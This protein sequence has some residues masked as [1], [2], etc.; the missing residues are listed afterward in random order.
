MNKI[1]INE[2][3][4]NIHPIYNLYAAN[5]DGFIINIVK[6]EPM[7][8]NKE[9]NGYMMC[10]VKKYGCKHKRYYVHR[11]VW[12]CFN[13]IIPEGE[14][15]DHINNIKDDN[16]LCNLQLM[17]QKQNCKK[18]AKDRDY[19]IAA[20]N[21][22]NKKCVKA[23]NIITKEVS[24]FN[25]MYAIQQHLGINVGIVSMCCQ[26]INNVKSGISKK[27][28]NSYTFEYVKKEDMPDDYKKII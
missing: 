22:D 8:G 19:T 18:L 9:V 4:Y 28:G 12:E 3:V 15:I 17:T 2:C 6:L 23:T 16:R 20:K 1:E 14:V 27:D 13:G 11:F 25:S 7:K 10:G 21:H 26:G 5:E 24:Y